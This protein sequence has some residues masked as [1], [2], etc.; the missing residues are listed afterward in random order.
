V[1]AGFTLVELLV[2]IAIIGILAALLLP[3]L[4]KA[5]ARGQDMSCRNNLKQLQLAWLN[6]VEDYNGVMPPNIIASTPL[7]YNLPGSWVLGNA[8]SNVAPSDI[9]S[10]VLYSY[11]PSPGVYRC[12]ANP[13]IATSA[14][15]VKLPVIRSYTLQFQLNP[16]GP[17]P[18]WID[19]PYPNYAKLSSIPAPAPVSLYVFIEPNNES[20]NEGGYFLTDLDSNYWGDLPDDLHARGCNLS[21][22]DGRAD[23]YK[24]KWPKKG[25]PQRDLVANKSDRDDY[26]RL[27][28]GRARR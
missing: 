8:L 23:H 24:W 2:V 17:G 20:L 4:S 3:A 14:P 22:A 27:R 12:P 15:G 1:Q 10:G 25:R 26:N 7:W 13:A 6:Y 18:N 9:K 5:K 19:R 11:T 28:D 16:S 21:F